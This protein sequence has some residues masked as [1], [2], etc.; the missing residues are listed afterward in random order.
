MNNPYFACRC[1][2]CRERLIH[3]GCREV[4][5]S[6][7]RWPDGDWALEEIGRRFVASV[8]ALT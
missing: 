6:V 5:W 1:Q 8:E 3:E 2:L 7:D 4:S